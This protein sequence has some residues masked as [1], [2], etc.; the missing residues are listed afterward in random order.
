MA[1]I[2]RAPSTFKLSGL[3]P[4]ELPESAG[5][6]QEEVR[7]FVASELGA[8]HVQTGESWN[9]RSAEFSRKLGVRGWI[10]MGWP[11]RYGGHERSL[12]D[13]FIVTEELLAA[14][15]P[16]GAHW[17]ADRQSGPLMLRYGTEEQRR[18][19]LPGIAAGELYFSIG[20]SEPDAGSDLAA[21][22]TSATKVDG[23]WLVNGRKTWTSG[24]HVCH[25]MI[26]L[27]RTSAAEDRHQGLTQLVV[28]L[29][30]PGL[31]ITP[32]RYMTG[33]HHW[34]DVAFTDV[35]VPDEMVVGEVGSGWRQV[36]SEL[37]LE[38]S[39]PERFL[40]VMPLLLALVDEVGPQP[41]E[42]AAAA[43]GALYAQLWTLRRMAMAVAA[44]MDRGGTPAVEAALVKDLGTRFEGAIVDTAR[45]LVPP[46]HRRPGGVFERLLEHA[47]LS[48]PSFTLRGGT[49]EILRSVVARGLGAR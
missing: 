2:E 17:I 49:S 22:R 7:S 37:A 47:V 15:A 23:G 43:L 20:M 6:L 24:A 3:P 14:G 4:A 48:R 10:G 25:F 41:D 32:I 31:E 38:R 28:D 11:E 34:D 12:L 9:N 39:G 45:E 21:V 8:D 5:R 44:E 35:L 36:T 16:V 18:R 19:F 40:S 27:C 30:S 29:A 46:G 1:A 33:E 26:T 13:R 42:R